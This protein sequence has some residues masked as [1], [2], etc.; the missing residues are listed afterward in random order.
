MLTSPMTAKRVFLLTIVIAASGFV[1]PAAALAA[2]IVFGLLLPH[3]FAAESRD[4]SRVRR[5]SCGF[6]W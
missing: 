1:S 6:Q 4:L 3:P 2:G 5:R